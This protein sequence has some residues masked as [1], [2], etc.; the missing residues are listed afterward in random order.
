M[1]EQLEIS[2]YRSCLNTTLN[3]QPDLSVLIGPNGSGKTNILNSLVLLRSLT[4]E[5][6]F[7]RDDQPTNE[8]R[9]KAAFRHHNGKAILTSGIQ[10]LPM[11]SN[12]GY[13]FYR[14]I[15]NEDGRPV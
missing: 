5:E 7:R 2:D 12:A 11:P 14:F 10:R 13:E 9:I 8:S 4:T 6:R 15:P 3:L 1:I